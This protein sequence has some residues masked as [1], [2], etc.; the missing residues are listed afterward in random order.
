MT[1]LFARGLDSR[2]IAGRQLCCIGPRTAE[3]L[4][5][6]GVKADVVPAEYQAEG[7]LATLTRQDVKKP[8]S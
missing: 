1:W 8:V 3:E 7:V 6:F 2:C 5:K 4:E